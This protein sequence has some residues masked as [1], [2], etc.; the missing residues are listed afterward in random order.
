MNERGTCSIDGKH[1]HLLVQFDKDVV[2]IQVEAQIENRNT[3]L[4]EKRKTTEVIHQPFLF[5][6]AWASTTIIHK[7]K[8]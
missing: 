4:I 5:V 6:L 2:G 1:K 8:V 3:T 7:F